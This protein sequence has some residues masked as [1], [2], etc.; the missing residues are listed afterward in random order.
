MSHR[1]V[2]PL[3]VLAFLVPL[4]A[5]QSDPDP[6]VYTLT[7]WDA[8]HHV[9]NVEVTFR[10]VPAGTLQARM[11]RSSPGR[12]AIHEF[13]KNVYDVKAFDGKG[14]AL[15]IARPNPYQWDVAGHDGTVRI[16]YRI[17]GDLVDGT[18]LG[19][20]PSHAHMNLPATL[21]WARGFE[22]RPARVTFTPPSGSGWKPATQLFPTSDPWTFT[23]PNMQY[24]FDSPTE[25]SDH[26]LREF[27]VRN[28]DGK[29]YTI[30]TAIHTTSSPQDVEEYVRGVQRIV[31]ETVTVFGEY[32]AFDTGTYTFLA[33]YLPTN[34]GDGMEH[35]NSTVV[36][37][38]GNIRNGLG[39]AS[40]EFFHAWNVER[41]RPQGLEPFDY[42]EANLTDSLWVAEGFTQYYGSLIMGRA[43]LS[44]LNRTVRGMGSLA[45]SAIN[46]SGRQFRSPVEM[47]HHAPFTDAARSVDP[48]NFAITFISYYTYGGA[49]ALGLDLSLRDRTNGAVTL[50]DFMRAMWRV[51]GKPDGPQP[52]LVAN[53]YALTDLRDRLAEVAGDR[54]FAEDFYRRYMIGREVV[55]YKRLFARAGLVLRTRYPG[56]GW[57]G[58]LRSATDATRISNLQAP[59]TPAYEAGL[60]SGDQITE[61][62]GKAVSSIAQAVEAFAARKPGD[63]VSVAVKRR[64][65]NALATRIV[66]KEN[67]ELEA[68]LLEETGAT[69]T[70]EQKTFRDRWLGSQQRPGSGL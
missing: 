10:S 13:A 34:A 56:R 38:R 22:G 47:S 39:T 33:D 65:G 41:I 19:I 44:D 25:L 46:D 15:T 49:V 8:V 68:V 2:T 17:F 54:A 6:V 48:T 16:T 29:S 53:P 45:D 60:E 9:A 4:T 62:D 37:G 31:N 1:L 23:A 11:S 24:L 43:G 55:D 64:D 67:P 18:Y 35:R 57:A 20:D 66:L 36:S 61:V 5:R 63:S 42:E 69:P 14:N 32:P 12:Y 27:S 59:G 26:L 50:D 7:F 58:D 70:P 28:A 30:R 3:I 40:H 52:G 51:H 21:M